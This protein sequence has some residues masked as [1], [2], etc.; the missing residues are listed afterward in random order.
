MTAVS[1]A[2]NSLFSCELRY[3]DVVDTERCFSR[4]ILPRPSDDLSCYRNSRVSATAMKN[5]SVRLPL[6]DA[7]TNGVIGLA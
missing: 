1:R 6:T 2:G 3:C 4:G 5:D 7:T